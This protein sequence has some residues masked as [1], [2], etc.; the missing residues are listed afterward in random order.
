MRVGKLSSSKQHILTSYL[1]P[2]AFSE[3][4][5]QTTCKID[6]LIFSVFNTKVKNLMFAPPANWKISGV[7]KKPRIAGVFFSHLIFSHI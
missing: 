7:L 5:Q 2:A 1:S 4:N 3:Q 6:L